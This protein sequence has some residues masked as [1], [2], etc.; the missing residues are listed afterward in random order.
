MYESNSQNF[1]F[2]GNKDKNLGDIDR[3]QF[4][5]PLC[6]YHDKNWTWLD[7]ALAVKQRC[8]KVLI[9]QVCSLSGLSVIRFYKKIYQRKNSLQVYQFAITLYFFTFLVYEAETF[10]KQAEWS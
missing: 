8:R 3:F 6:E 2:Q 4:L 9:Q 5:F 10:K 7:L 1:S